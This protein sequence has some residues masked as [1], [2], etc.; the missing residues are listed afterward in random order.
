MLT[1]NVY[2]NISPPGFPSIFIDSTDVLITRDGH[3]RKWWESLVLRARHENNF[4]RLALATFHPENTK[5]IS[6]TKLIALREICSPNFVC[7]SA[8]ELKLIYNENI[9]LFAFNV[10]AAGWEEEWKQ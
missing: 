10:G 7:A 1:I 5:N 6:T 8:P 4:A 9:S 3:S 2:S